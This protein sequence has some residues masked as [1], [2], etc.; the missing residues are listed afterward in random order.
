MPDE[1]DG[2]TAWLTIFGVLGTFKI[3]TA[4]ML[5]FFYPSS[6]AI[7]FLLVFNWYWLI[8]PG[9]VVLIGLGVGY[10][11]F[12]ARARRRRMIRAEFSND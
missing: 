7:V 11:L 8:P 6:R 3:A 4:I 5:F 12:R 2:W 10:R 1:E 9:I